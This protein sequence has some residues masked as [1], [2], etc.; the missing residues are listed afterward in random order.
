[1]PYHSDNY[2]DK[3]CGQINVREDRSIHP[4]A[5]I[6]II[7]RCTYSFAWYIYIRGQHKYIRLR[8]TDAETVTR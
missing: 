7:K 6:F 5:I 1:M 8:Y 2:F 4:T 3:L